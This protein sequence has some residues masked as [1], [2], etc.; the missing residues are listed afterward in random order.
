MQ[1]TL[2]DPPPIVF[3]RVL[4]HRGQTEV[5]FWASFV[6]EPVCQIRE[7]CSCVLTVRL[8]GYDI[9]ELCAGACVYL[10]VVRANWEGKLC[11]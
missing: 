6:Y 10:R 7:I 11:F 9:M 1:M 3:L 2:G 8:Q 5:G 4:V